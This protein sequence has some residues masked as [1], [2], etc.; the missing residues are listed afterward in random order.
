[1]QS[2]NARI[3]P[4]SGYNRFIINYYHSWTIG[5]PSLNGHSSSKSRPHLWC[6]NFTALSIDNQVFC[7]I[8][9][10]D[11]I[12]F[13]AK[14]AGIESLFI[15]ALAILRRRL[16]RLPMSACFN[17]QSVSFRIMFIF[18]EHNIQLPV[19]LVF[20]APVLAHGMSKGFN[21]LQQDKKISAIFPF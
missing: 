2:S 8:Y 3:S 20:N 9:Q 1:M 17:R 14:I 21:I 18:T 7:Q 19:K 15:A 4:L 11:S 5:T 10:G 16:T 13:W 12:Y 6:F